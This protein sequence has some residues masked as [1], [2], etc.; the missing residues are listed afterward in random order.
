MSYADKSARNDGSPIRHCKQSEAI[1][2]KNSKAN[3][4]NG[5]PRLDKVKSRNDGL[6]AKLSNDKVSKTIIKKI[7]LSLIC[8]CM[9][10]S[11]A[12]ASWS[13][14]DITC[15]N[16]GACSLN[17]NVTNSTNDIDY[18]SDTPTGSSSINGS[19]LEVSALANQFLNKYLPDCQIL[20]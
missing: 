14:N 6:K 16:N 10:Q 1:H 2:K 9:L 20:F 8:A 4:K 3:S 12:V 5:L 15:D 11:Y 13:G 18:S 19:K 17:A 7:P